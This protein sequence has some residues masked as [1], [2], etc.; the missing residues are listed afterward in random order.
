MRE[1][2]YLLISGLQHFEY[3]K[4]QWALIHIEAQWEENYLTTSG[5]IVH[6]RAHNAALTEKRGDLI[7][8][9]DMAIVSHSL[10]AR[11][12]CDVV[13]FV[14]DES[15][16]SL[17]GRE[18]LWL[19][20]PVEYKRGKSKIHDADRL[21][22]CAQAICLEE[23]LA[24]P[25]IEQ[26]FLY[27][28]ETKRREAVDLTD[29]LRQKVRDMFEQMHDYHSRGHTPRV[30]ANAGCSACSLKDICLPDMPTVQS[31]SSYIKKALEDN[32]YA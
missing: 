4:R 28:N 15:G 17:F 5:Q 20:V 21:Q 25:P 24:A 3:C 9:R 23:M 31:V 32:D 8:T 6:K 12:K 30:K 19:P 1:E 7:I 2:E 22:L 18:G 10:K 26:A 14:R 16:V 13:E 27:Y 11:G 29:E